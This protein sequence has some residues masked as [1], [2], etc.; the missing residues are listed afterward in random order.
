MIQISVP[1]KMGSFNVTNLEISNVIINLNLYSLRQ[2]DRLRCILNNEANEEKLGEVQRKME[3]FQGYTINFHCGR[4]YNEQI[5]WWQVRLSGAFTEVYIHQ[6]RE[7]GRCPF[8][9]TVF[10]C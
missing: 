7:M 10:F 2:T 4:L 9:L 3:E 6:W 8:F 5:N 1:E